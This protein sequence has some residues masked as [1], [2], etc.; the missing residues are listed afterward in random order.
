MA[1][2]LAMQSADALSVQ[3][4]KTGLPVESDTAG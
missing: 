4:E 1:I 3:V 2:L